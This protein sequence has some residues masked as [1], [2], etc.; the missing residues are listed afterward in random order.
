[1]IP[2]KFNLIKEQK[3]C[4]L[5]QIYIYLYEIVYLYTLIYTSISKSNYISII[6][7]MGIILK[8]FINNGEERLYCKQ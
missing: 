5:I 2:M 4:Y 6:M 7:L 8:T 3:Y 1:M